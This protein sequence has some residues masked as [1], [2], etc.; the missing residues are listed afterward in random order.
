MAQGAGLQNTILFAQNADFSGNANI[1]NAAN[2]L[3]QDNQ[4][5]LGST[6]LNAGG[7][8]INVKTLTAGTGITFSS[9]SS[10]LTINSTASTTDLHVAKLIVN[11]VLNAGG[12]YTTIT[13]ALL[14]AN[15]GDTI[16]VMPGN[17]GIYTEDLTL[18]AGVNIVAFNADALTPNVT[19]VGKL[20][21][22]FAGTASISGIR[23]QTNSDFLLSVTGSSATTINLINCYLNCS[24]NTGIQSTSTSSQ[25]NVI[26]CQG[27]LGATSAI[28]T[29]SGGGSLYMGYCTFS[30]SGGSG[31]ATTASA[32]NYI[33]EYCE[34]TSKF[35]TS[36]TTSQFDIRYCL[37]ACSNPI[38]HNSTN[39]VDSALR[40]SILAAGA[41]VGI[42][43][44]AGAHLNIQ[45]CDI[46]ST[47]TTPISNS[48]TL[49]FDMIAYNSSSQMALRYIQTAVSY[50]VLFTDVIIGV[51]SNAAARTITM[52]NSSMTPGQF[53]I[54]KDEAGTA[55]SANNITISGNGAN[56][57][58]SA[59]FVINTNYGACELYWNG[60][61]FFVI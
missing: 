35:S 19:I 52:P 7:T 26:N 34:F 41:T 14:A 8:N 45:Q 44:G 50:Q 37:F 33:L 10:A 61:N 32:G 49:T 13:A 24:N 53:W 48:G 39:V 17:N 25:I 59:T 11:S 30:N 40:H 57:D 27:D 18:K 9:S 15:S 43:V 16:F 6:A 60:S 2:M 58:G 54:I 56:I 29:L 42:S 1:G 23:L 12:N 4:I 22:T 3:T 5:W 31:T 36:G 38:T 21:A 46:Q 51:T 28:F 47:N 55:Q 20:T